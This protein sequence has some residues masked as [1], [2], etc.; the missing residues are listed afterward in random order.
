MRQWKRGV[1]LRQRFMSLLSYNP[2]WKRLSFPQYGISF[3]CSNWVYLYKI[4]GDN[5]HGFSITSQRVALHLRQT[6][7]TATPAGRFSTSH[8]HTKVILCDMVDLYWVLLVIIFFW[9]FFYPIAL[10]QWAVHFFPSLCA[11]KYLNYFVNIFIASKMILL[12]FFVKMD[13]STCTVCPMLLH[14]FFRY[15]I[16]LDEVKPGDLS[17]NFLREFMDLPLSYL[18]PGASMKFRKCNSLGFK[19]GH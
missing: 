3:F 1:R 9:I 4:V 10:L 8:W 6:L 12:L 2:C 19:L 14:S 15:E 11:L 16:Y 18:A 13:W 5:A 17:I 7:C